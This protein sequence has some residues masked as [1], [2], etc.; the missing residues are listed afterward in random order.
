MNTGPA[1]LFRISVA[2][3]NITDRNRGGGGGCSDKQTY[4]LSKKILNDTRTLY[5]S[6]LYLG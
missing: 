4:N 1:H 3:K 6:I 2:K 5:P